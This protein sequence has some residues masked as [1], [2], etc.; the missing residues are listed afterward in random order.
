MTLC[1]RNASW[2][3]EP[4]LTTSHDVADTHW[5]RCGERNFYVIVVG[6]MVFIQKN[7]PGFWHLPALNKSAHGLVTHDD[8]TN[9]TFRCSAKLGELEFVLRGLDSDGSATIGNSAVGALL[10]RL[11]KDGDGFSLR[12]NNGRS[13][14]LDSRFCW[15]CHQLFIDNIRCSALAAFHRAAQAMSA[16]RKLRA[17]RD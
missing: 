9:L 14:Y 2:R 4:V 17:S 11:Q 3:L 5:Q 6:A 12:V 15:R 13:A 16:S 7:W 8:V 10:L 1:L